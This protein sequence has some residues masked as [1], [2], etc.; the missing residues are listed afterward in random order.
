[1]ILDKQA[2]AL[3]GNKI[4]TLTSLKNKD[5]RFAL[6]LEIGEIWQNQVQ[7]LPRAIAAYVDATKIKPDDRPTLH[8]L[9][10]L[11]Q[12]VEQWRELAEVIAHV[13][14]LEEDGHHSTGH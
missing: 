2:L 14:E 13:A 11:Y 4:N 12:A 6:L 8:K 1:M 10:P 7:H 9:I 5:E 3:V